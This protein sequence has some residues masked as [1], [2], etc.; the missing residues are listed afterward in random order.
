MRISPSQ[1]PRIYLKLSKHRL[2]CKQDIV[3]YSVRLL[4]VALVVLTAL[5]GYSIAPAPLEWSTLTWAMMGTTLCSAAANTGN[6]VMTNLFIHNCDSLCSSH[7]IVAFYCSILVV[8]GPIRFSNGSY[9]ES[10]VSKKP[11]KVCQ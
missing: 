9:K 4:L 5:L 6:Q 1:L 8:R 7:F 2:T 11:Y 10:C 3:C